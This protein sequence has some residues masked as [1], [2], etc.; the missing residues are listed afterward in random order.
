MERESC[1]ASECS[2]AWL[3]LVSFQIGKLLRSIE[4][5][6][7]LKQKVARDAG[8]ASENAWKT[9]T[10]TYGYA[11]GTESGATRQPKLIRPLIH[12]NAIASLDWIGKSAPVP[13]LPCL[14]QNNPGQ[15]QKNP[16]DYKGHT[17]G[18]HTHTHASPRGG[19]ENYGQDGCVNVRAAKTKERRHEKEDKT[20]QKGVWLQ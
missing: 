8:S 16:C 14:K 6:T 2:T 4:E 17:Q 1:G 13:L 18:A 20:G 5:V 7:F 12:R 19:E 9:H 3:Q 15:I 11:Y 10:H